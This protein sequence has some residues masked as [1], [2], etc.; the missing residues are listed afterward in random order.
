VHG[1]LLVKPLKVVLNF[2]LIETLPDSLLA[3]AE[4]M[5][6]AIKNVKGSIKV[7]SSN[8]NFVKIVKERG[9]NNLAEIIEASN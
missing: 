5:V 2:G 3:K 4:D 6:K 1:L 7:V 9:I 8:K